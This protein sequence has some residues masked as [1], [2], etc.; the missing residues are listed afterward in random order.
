MPTF[1]QLALLTLGA[2]VLLALVWAWS[3]HR[4]LDFRRFQ[5]GRERSSTASDEAA[6]RIELASVR[7]RLRKLEAIAAGV[8]P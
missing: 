5:I 3:W 8:D 1:A 2:L 6:H 7:E 4:W